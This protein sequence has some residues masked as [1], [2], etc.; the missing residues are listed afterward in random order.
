MVRTVMAFTS[1]VETPG[2]LGGPGQPDIEV[3]S[4]DAQGNGY[5]LTPY[6]EGLQWSSVNPGGDELCSFRLAREWFTGAPEV[7]KGNRLEVQSSAE[8]LWRGRIDESEGQVEQAEMIGVTAYGAG[9]ALRDSTMV[10]IYVDGELAAFAN[11]PSI[12]RQLQNSPTF[13][14]VGTAQVVTDDADLRPAL[15][16]QQTRI[17]NAA[18]TRIYV[19]ES[20]YRSPVALES[21]HH[22][23]TGYDLVNNAVLTGAWDVKVILGD[24]DTFVSADASGDLLATSG[25]FQA[26]TDARQC[27]A[28]QI[29]FDAT[30]AATDGSWNAYVREVRAYGRH[31]LT[32]Q[33]P[34]PGG[35]FGSQVVRDI[36]QRVAG[37]SI[38]RI[39][40]SGYVIEDI[41]FRTPTQHEEAIK[42]ASKFDDVDWGTW[43]P[44]SVLDRSKLGRFDW[45]Q[46]EP[47][48]AHWLTFRSDCEQV[49][50]NTELSTLHNA[51]DVFWTDTAGA[52]HVTRRTTVVPELDEANPPITK[53]GRVDG[54]LRSSE[55]ADQLG[56][57]FLALSGSRAPARG[58]LVIVKQLRHKSRGMVAPWLM[59]ADG[60]NIRVPDVLPSRELLSLS[61]EPDRRSTFPIKRVHVDCSGAVPRVSVSVDQA[62]DVMS[63]LQAQLGAASER[64]GQG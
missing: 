21:V 11:S 51:V 26:T 24:D 23:T 43:A 29:L 42:E 16:L 5:D 30:Q 59:R 27:V 18:G 7:K 57:A 40:D 31:G 46:A 1:S 22:D 4:F 34:D 56:D 10:E 32:K 61:R 55:G 33:G 12:Q 15:Q 3:R 48:E 39:D 20:L 64:V 53:V 50:I 52:E 25:Y 45:K 62:V 2:G 36:V 19:T 60:A 41:K 47:T 17:D 38:R 63:Q 58:D 6:V 14:F 49:N 37:V 54:G 44:N 13:P 28:F 9:I 8:V 35:F